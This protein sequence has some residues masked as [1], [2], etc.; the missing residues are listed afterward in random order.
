MELITLGKCTTYVEVAVQNVLKVL[1]FLDIDEERGHKVDLARKVRMLRELILPAS[2]NV[3]LAK[4]ARFARKGG[5]H[6]LSVDLQLSRLAQE[7]ACDIAEELG[8]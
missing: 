4:E 8:S 7:S 3:L 5:D 2:E 1:E 6:R